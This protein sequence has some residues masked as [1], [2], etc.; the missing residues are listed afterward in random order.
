MSP[1]FVAVFLGFSPR[2]SHAFWVRFPRKIFMK[3]HGQFMANS[4]W[5]KREKMHG[6]LLDISPYSL[7]KKHVLPQ[8][9]GHKNISPCFICSF[10]LLSKV[11][12]SSG[13]YIRALAMYASVNFVQ[14]V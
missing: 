1:L 8:V 7:C 5:E 13:W 12:E 14:F 3:I 2:F 6:L 4:C 10:V 11:Q 9:F